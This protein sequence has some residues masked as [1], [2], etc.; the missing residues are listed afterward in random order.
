MGS[1]VKKRNLSAHQKQIWFFTGLGIFIIAL[2]TA[3][4]FWLANAPG[5]PGR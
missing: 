3:L 4:M 5:F 2:F 1:H